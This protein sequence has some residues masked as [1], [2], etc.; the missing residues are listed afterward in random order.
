[1][2]N[3]NIEDYT[4]QYLEA[5][6]LKENV[7][8]RREC[9]C[10]QL[11]KYKHKTI[12]EIGCGMFP[13]FEYLEKNDYERYYIIE[14]S[15]FF[16]ENAKKKITG[17]LEKKVFIIE[18]YFE[19]KYREILEEKFDFIICSSLLHE[20]NNATNL[21]QTIYTVAACNT[22][23]HINVPNANSMHRLIAKEMGI[24][25]NIYSKSE[26]QCKLQQRE[27]Y[28]LEKLK[29][30][31]VENEFQIIDEGS[32]FIKPFTHT[33]M[34]LMLKQGIIDKNVLLGLQGII[35]YFPENGSEIYVNVRRK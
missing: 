26:T 4:E 3:R 5:P 19:D 33:Q 7:S 16:V 34:D 13:L 1:M 29:K 17:E 20:V 12:L 9:V 27:V 30:E 15:P 21:L 35:K 32:Y 23:I 31:L 24:I 8:Y 2:V 11:K 14:P 25:D 22:I 10:E 6:F 18:G 28:D